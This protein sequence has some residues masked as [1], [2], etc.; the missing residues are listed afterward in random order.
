MADIAAAQVFDK[1]CERSQPDSYQTPED[2]N[3]PLTSDVSYYV[4]HVIFTIDIV[5]QV[6]DSA[7]LTACTSRANCA[8]ST[9]AHLRSRSYLEGRLANRSKGNGKVMKCTRGVDGTFAYIVTHEQTIPLG[10][11]LSV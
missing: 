1:V 10:P 6:W 9:S 4:V 2:R 3:L 11:V 7:L 8:G 5:A